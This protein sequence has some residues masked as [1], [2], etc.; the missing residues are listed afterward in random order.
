MSLFRVPYEFLGEKR[1][2]VIDQTKSEDLNQIITRQINIDKDFHV[3]VKSINAII[4]FTSEVFEGDELII[5]F[6]EVQDSSVSS[7]QDS[8]SQP[9]EERANE[10]LIMVKTDIEDTFKEPI[11]V[12]DLLQ[13]I[14][15][16]AFSKDFKVKVSGGQKFGKTGVTK[17]FRCSEK[18]CNFQLKFYS[19]YPLNKNE[20]N[21]E[22]ISYIIKSSFLI[23]NHKSTYCKMTLLKKLLKKLML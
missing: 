5:E 20:L 18:K 21:T 7:S 15:D 10:N 17:T 19:E 12:Q 9:E 11:K 6:K 23:H 13:K 1:L 2:I 3:K 14:N 8:Q 4:S 22:K 16:W